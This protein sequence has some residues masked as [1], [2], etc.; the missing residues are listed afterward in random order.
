MTMTFSCVES[1]L[2]R[3]APVDHNYDLQRTVQWATGAKAHKP[4]P[5]PLLL[6][7]TTIDNSLIV[8]NLG[9]EASTNQICRRSRTFCPA[10]H[11]VYAGCTPSMAASTKAAGRR[12]RRGYAR[13]RGQSCLR[14]AGAEHTRA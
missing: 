9:F 4:S 11:A 3:T 7:V 5:W 2:L 6:T 1:V 14:A 13:R 12:R 10:L 8:T